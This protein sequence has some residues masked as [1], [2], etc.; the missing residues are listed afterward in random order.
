[1]SM[2]LRRIA[3]H[4]IALHL[5]VALHVVCGTHAFAVQPDEMMRDPLQEAR[6]CTLLYQ[7]SA[8]TKTE[9]EDKFA[10]IGGEKNFKPQCGPTNGA[11]MT[12]DASHAAQD[13]R[14]TQIVSGD[15]KAGDLVIVGLATTKASATG[16]SPLAGP[17]APGGPGGGRRGF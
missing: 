1:M 2:G 11:F 7:C 4:L 12:F 13:G 5:I 14:F 3:F 6:I 8:A 17:R 16:N 15:V 10:L 9:A